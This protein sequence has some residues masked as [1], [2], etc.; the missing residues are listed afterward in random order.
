MASN[1]RTR[2][3]TRKDGENVQMNLLPEKERGAPRGRY[4]LHMEQSGRTSSIS[5]RTMRAQSAAQ[6]PLQDQQNLLDTTPVDDQIGSVGIGGANQDFNQ[7]D[8]QVNGNN[9]LQIVANLFER[10]MQMQ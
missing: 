9:D 1:H 10:Q 5:Q 7:N 4:S 3:Q 6:V 2:S 8:N